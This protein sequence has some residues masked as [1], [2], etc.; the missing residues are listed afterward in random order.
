MDTLSIEH[1]IVAFLGDA[2][3]GWILIFYKSTRNK[4]YNQQMNKT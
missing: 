1:F 2:T 4:A 3:D